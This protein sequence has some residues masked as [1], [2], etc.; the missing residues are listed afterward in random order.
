MA[1]CAVTVA[2]KCLRSGSESPV[3]SPPAMRS[4][5]N[6]L[7][8]SSVPSLPS[9]VRR[10]ACSPISLS[11]LSTS[12]RPTRSSAPALTRTLKAVEPRTSASTSSR[13]YLATAKSKAGAE[14][15]LLMVRAPQDKVQKVNLRL[16]YTS[17]DHGALHGHRF[18]VAALSRELPAHNA[19]TQ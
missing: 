7:K 10:R 2:H 3:N 17:T 1:S 14:V 19:P 12:S 4:Q 15:E 18:A 13:R 16:G 11:S 5:S 6:P 8:S 9:N